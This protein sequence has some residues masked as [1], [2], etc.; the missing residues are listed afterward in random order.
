MPRVGFELT[1]P[2]F[3]RSKIVRA[4]DGAAIGTGSQ[5]SVNQLTA[6]MSHCFLEQDSNPRY[7]CAN[8]PDV[9]IKVTAPSI[10]GTPHY[11]HI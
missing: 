7:Q 9:K 4:L 6:K 2:M 5:I 8:G 3:E 1:I 11:L 10:E